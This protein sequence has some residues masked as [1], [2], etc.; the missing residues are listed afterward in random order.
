MRARRG[1]VWAGKK[2]THIHTRT[3]DEQ[4]TEASKEQQKQR[5]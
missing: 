2:K 4:A 5:K 3:D 1:G